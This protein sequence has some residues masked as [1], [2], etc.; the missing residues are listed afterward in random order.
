MT[1]PKAELGDVRSLIVDIDGVLWHG[2]EQLPGVVP[3][4]EFLQNRS[5]KFIIATNNSARP[6]SAIRR[7]LQDLGISVTEQQVL[8]SA[9]ATALFL[10]RIAAPGARVLVV[11][12]EGI[13]AELD[14]AGYVLVDTNAGV[15]VVG[16]D[17]DLTYEKLK[18]ATFEIRRGALFV[19]TNGDR[20]FPIADGLAPGAGA[21][22]A[23]LV[24][25]TDRE[26]TVIGKPERPMFDL[27]VERM[28]ASKETTA[29][30]GDRLDT[31]VQGARNAGLLSILVLTGVTSQE[32]LMNSS[33]QPD[34]VFLN[35]V[36]LQNAWDRALR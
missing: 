21:I 33:I 3:F 14:R 17:T 24:A 29:M 4:L 7:R 25:A 6:V 16:L 2:T 35:L 22:L 5:I 32:L 31:D 18:A 28:Q 19:G 26:P 30:L 27:A 12:G 23:A 8:T 9:Q 34:F 1:Q 13:A 20:T 36:D 15:V 11:G 10:P